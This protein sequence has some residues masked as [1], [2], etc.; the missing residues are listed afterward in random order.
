M[1]L[2]RGVFCVTMAKE[3]ADWPFIEHK[4]GDENTKRKSI[5]TVVTPS[6]K[7]DLANCYK[8]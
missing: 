7:I 8:M 1:S 6:L 3:L 2:R 5:F 4:H